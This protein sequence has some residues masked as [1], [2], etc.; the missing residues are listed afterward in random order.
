VL[1]AEAD[2]S[3]L[4]PAGN[5][6][7]LASEIPDT[8]QYFNRVVVSYNRLMRAHEGRLWMK[9]L[10]AEVHTVDGFGSEAIVVI[11][12]PGTPEARRRKDIT[13]SPSAGGGYEVSFAAGRTA[14]YLVSEASSA[15]TPRVSAD[16]PSRLD[17]KGNKADYLIIAPRT[18][19]K[20]ATAL[21]SYRGGRFS[22]KI[23]W[24]EDIY[25]EFTHGRVD[26]A[27]VERF[28][29]LVHRRWRRAPEY[30]ALLG[31]GT[32]D[33]RDRKGYSD[34]LIPVLMTATP[35]GLYASDNRYAD[36]DGDGVAEFALG[37]IPVSND[38]EGLA[39]VKKLKAYEASPSGGWT[40]RAVVA[41]DNPDNAGDFHAGSD[42]IAADLSA[43]GYTVRRAYHP[44]DDLRGILTESAT[45]A[46]A[47]VNYVGHGSRM[48]LG[49]TSEG[50]LKSGDVP[51]LKNKVLLPLFAALTCS[52]GDDTYPGDDSVTGE[53]VRH[54]AGGAVAALAPTGL[55]LDSDAHVLNRAF[56]RGL[57]SD[58]RSIGEAWRESQAA[59]ARES[60]SPF[61]LEIYQVTGD[62]AV[63]L[64]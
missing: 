24:V 59:G 2:Q 41:A 56:V 52:V 16:L 45:W 6:L 39:Y 63:H 38:K 26:P 42:V 1:E 37:R 4:K 20:T 40:G 43:E 8:F 12:D 17:R 44:D 61:M 18:L 28:L 51:S 27:A 55:S 29:S 10:P 31:R 60:I 36:I 5:V 9:A 7:K 64:P 48:Q 14:D 35:W 21:A 33:H 58:G 25:D 62:P 53:L 47:Y 23:A 30:V 50:F 34:S 57:A 19:S 32:L 46:S 49:S 15:L 3:L 11:E 54:G 22:V 13:V